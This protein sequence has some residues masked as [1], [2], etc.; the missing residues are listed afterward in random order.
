MKFS[1][2]VGLGPSHIVL[3]GD[4]GPLP[5]KGHS[6]PPLLAHDYCGQTA[7]WIQDAT[8]YEGRPGPRPHCVRWGSS[9][10]PLKRGTVPQFSSLVYCDQMVT[11]LSYCWAFVR[12]YMHR[13]P[14][15]SS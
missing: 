6:S 1:V 4:P 2:E 12:K 9:F 5:K 10:P 11:H 3:D 14:R 7:R 13:Q 15:S 8:W